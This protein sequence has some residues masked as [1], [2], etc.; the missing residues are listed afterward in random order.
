MVVPEEVAERLAAKAVERG[1]TPESVAAEVLSQHTPQPSNGRRFA[2]IGMF[3]SWTG[4]SVAEAERQL[5][6]GEDEGFGQ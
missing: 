3:D 5:E 2:F 6:D 4:P 1:T